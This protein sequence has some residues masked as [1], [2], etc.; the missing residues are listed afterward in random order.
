MTQPA[1]DPAPV[2]PAPGVPAGDD[3]ET[4]LS[5]RALLGLGAVFAALAGGFVLWQRTS[6]F[7]PDSSPE[8]AY[9]RVAVAVADGRVRDCFAYL[10]DQAQHAAYTI[11]DYRKRAADRVSAAY[12]EPERSRLLAAYKA[13]A[14][15]PDGADVWKEM[16]ERRGWIGRLRKDLSGAAKVELSGER[17][18]IETAR[19]TRYTLRRRPNGIWGLTMFTAELLAESERAARDAEVVEK[20]AADY[21]RAREK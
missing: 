3:A 15:A 2:P 11:R 19:G 4:G 9:L 10:E 5:R 12:P 16:A 13:H 6:R 1:P 17:A 8:G 14:E 20:A 18:T 7:P 21:E